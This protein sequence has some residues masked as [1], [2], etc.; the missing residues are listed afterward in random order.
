MSF[1]QGTTKPVVRLRIFGITIDELA[2]DINGIVPS[3][4]E[5]R[6]AGFLDDLS[7]RSLFCFCTHSGVPLNT[8]VLA[9]FADNMSH[10][11]PGSR[12]RDLDVSHFAQQRTRVL[13]VDQRI[14]SGATAP[15]SLI[16]R[17]EEHFD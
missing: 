13:H 2:I 14:A 4:F 15:S 6:Q 5:R 8:H 17:I 3:T 9:W 16:E 1:H 11:I 12:F 7:S 10:H